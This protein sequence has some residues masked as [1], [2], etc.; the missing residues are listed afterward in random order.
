MAKITRILVGIFC[1]GITAMGIYI[2][3]FAHYVVLFLFPV[4]GI[5][6]LGIIG[7]CLNLSSKEPGQATP[8]RKKP[9]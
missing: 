2:F 5:I 3:C 6:A 4:G 7:F 8:R 9:E 1:L